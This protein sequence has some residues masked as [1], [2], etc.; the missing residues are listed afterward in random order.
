MAKASPTY[1]CNNAQI[2][3]ALGLKATRKVL[4]EIGAWRARAD[5]PQK[6]AGKSGWLITELKVWYRHFLQSAIGGNGKMEASG[7][8]MAKAGPSSIIHPSSSPAELPAQEKP[9]ES[10]GD[11]FLKD[12][13]KLKGR[14]ERNKD[15]YY[16]PDKYPNDKIAKW[17]V[18]ELREYGEIP[19]SGETTTA[20]GEAG[21]AE[22]VTTQKAILP[23]LQK[24]YA[25]RLV[26]EITIDNISKWHSGRDVPVEGGPPAPHKDGNYFYIAQWIE[27]CD[28]WVLPAWAIRPDDQTPGLFSSGDMARLR[29][30]DERELIEH[31]RFLRESERG[32]WIR[33]ADLCPALDAALAAWLQVLDRGELIIP[34]GLEADFKELDVPE[35]LRLLLMERVR[36]RCANHNDEQHRALEQQMDGLKAKAE[37]L[38]TES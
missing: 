37:T 1:A 5:F 20:P 13:D 21:K 33:K 38:K 14:L 22:K 27:W 31:N 23:Y 19:N 7:S 18:D 29:K 8:K 34:K 11:L 4:A 32:L 10:P 24:H 36:A 25:G 15:R 26:N 28:R 35:D 12:T 2:A 30:E 6:P 9:A 17:E 3:A 16:N